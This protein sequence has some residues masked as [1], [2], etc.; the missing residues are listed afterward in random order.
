MAIFHIRKEL[1]DQSHADIYFRVLGL[2]KRWLVETSSHVWKCTNLPSSCRRWLLLRAE[3][4][5][6]RWC[7]PSTSWSNQFCFYC[8]GRSVREGNQRSIMWLAALWS[9]CWIPDTT[10]ACIPT[11]SNMA[12]VSSVTQP[13]C[14]Y[15]GT[16]TFIR[17]RVPRRD[18]LFVFPCAELCCQI[19]LTSM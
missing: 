12:Q 9:N 18:G 16:F 4:Q 2:G 15:T 3:T 5:R 6:W 8:C 13:G 7:T 1:L 11:M 10:S 14:I 17:Y 19:R